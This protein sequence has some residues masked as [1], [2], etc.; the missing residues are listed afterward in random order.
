MHGYDIHEALSQIYE[1]HGPWIMGL[2]TRLG[3]IIRIYTSKIVL[4]LRNGYIVNDA[5]YQ[6][7][8]NNSPLLRGSVSLAG[9]ISP[10][11]KIDY[12]LE[13]LFY[14]NMYLRKTKCIYLTT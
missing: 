4:N 7:L 3:P 11:C 14:S 10:Y 9:P 1:N 8:E 6:S 2:D 13:N 5:L 12:I